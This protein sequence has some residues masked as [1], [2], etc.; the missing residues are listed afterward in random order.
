MYIS[1]NF[2]EFRWF[3]LLAV[4][5]QVWVKREELHDTLLE[6]GTV[7]ILSKS[8]H[9]LVLSLTFVLQ[10]WLKREELHDYLGKEVTAL[11]DDICDP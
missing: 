9:C 11:T 1:L 6:G 8:S 4:V 2:T 3:W 7:L 5:W 10:M